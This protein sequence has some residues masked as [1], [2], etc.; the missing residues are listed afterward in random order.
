MKLVEKQ[1]N[2][3]DVDDSYRLAHC[4]SSDCRMGAGIAVEFQNRFNL[5]DQL[6]SIP[7]EQRI[8]P[9]SHRV[10][11]VYNLMT[12]NRYFDKPTYTTLSVALEK[13]KHQLIWDDV[14]KIA[15]P[16]IGC[17][18]DGLNWACVRQIIERTFEDTDI[19]ILV[20]YL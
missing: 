9:A 7:A 6:L 15:I 17:G 2:L 12:K 19:E 1:F 5:R 13:L 8:Y 14:K 18:L 4:I 11:R 10:G 16:R 20:C 3:F